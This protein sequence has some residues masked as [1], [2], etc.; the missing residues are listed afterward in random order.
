MQEET[1]NIIKDKEL[2]ESMDYQQLRKEAVAITQNISGSIWTD[3]NIHD[4]GVTILEQFCYAL[5]DI[6]Y[7]TN[8]SIETLLFHA[9]DTKGIAESNALF[10][11]E[12]I[13]PTG[14]ITVEDYTIL[15]LDELPNKISNCWVE[16]IMDHHE[17]IHGL[18]QI[19]LILKND[20]AASEH[21]NIK[22]EV[23]KI[24]V[25][26]RNLCEDIETIEIIKPEKIGISADI[27][28]F[29]DEV[30]DE[31]LAEILFQLEHYF[32]PIIQFS[33]LE[34]L[35]EKG[36]DLDEIFNAPSHKH[37]FIRKEQLQP[38]QEE[39][40]VSKIADHI[41]N[42][43]GV[44]NLRNL[45]VTQGQIPVHGDIIKVPSDKYLTLGL[46]G[47]DEVSSNFEGFNI[48]L[49]KGGI[50]NNYMEE[51]VAYALDIK[52]AKTHRNYEISTKPKKIETEKLRIGNLTNYE[53]IQKSFPRIYG[54]GHYF[55]ANEEGKLR[56]AQSS[57]LQAYLMF[58][59]QIMANHLAHLSKIS[60]LL[61]IEYAEK[62]RQ[63][64]YFSQLLS[65]D[66]PGADDLI[67]RK[68]L[69]KSVI[70]KRLLELKNSSSALSEGEEDEK[71]NLNLDLSE[72]ERL[73]KQLSSKKL[74]ELLKMPKS[75][76]KKYGFFENK[77]IV[78]LA[79]GFKED[80][81]AEEEN[82]K[83]KGAIEK[84]VSAK[85]NK[86]QEKKRK[87]IEILIEQELMEKEQF[88]PLEKRHLSSLNRQ[89]DP[90]S[91]RKNRLLTHMLARFGERFTT[92][93][94]I[95]FNSL[96]EGETQE[97]VNNKLTSLKSAF[98]KEIIS[99]SRFRSRGLNYLSKEKPLNTSIPLKRRICLLLNID[100]SSDQKLASARLNSK[101]K[102]EK[103]TGQDIVR[104]K[105][106]DK[107]ISFIRPIQSKK[108]ITFLV[109]SSSYLTY[110]F[111]FGL[112]ISNYK[113]TE[114]DG[115]FVT[116]FSPPTGEDATWIFETGSK[117]EGRQKIEKLI[118]FLRKLNSQSEGFHIVEHILL[119]T[120]ERHECLFHILGVDGL[121]AFTSLQYLPTDE[122]RPKA[123]DALLLACYSNNY[124]IYETRN[125]EFGV[126]LRDAIGTDL[127]RS[128]ATFMTR[129]SAEGYIEESIAYFQTIKDSDSFDPYYELD[130]QK[131][132]YLDLLDEKGDVIFRSIQPYEIKEQEKTIS[133]LAFWGTKKHH[134]KLSD[135]NSKELPL[136]SIIDSDGLEIARS[137]VKFDSIE[138]EN[139]FVDKCISYFEALHETSSFE[140]K[141]QHRRV[142]GRNASEFNAQLSVV[143]PEW[144][145]RF[146]NQEFLQLF[147]QT[148]FNCAPAHL[149][150]N[151]V[152]LNHVEMK[153]FEKLYFKYITELA[154]DSNK[155]E[156]TLTKM[157]N[158]ILD[159]LNDKKLNQT[160]TNNP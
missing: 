131:K 94:H 77:R 121:T 129:I 67:Q 112:N 142:D 114:E 74:D 4:P 53:S 133:D 22:N 72:K 83:Q 27:D 78:M 111:K 92:D 3:Y 65:P 156:S 39:F 45:S 155:K 47:N 104:E 2:R 60:E 56:Q 136:V 157:S 122:Q 103:L 40:Y 101:L 51:A 132:Y 73:V 6:A 49:F 5:T 141:I 69:P 35:T 66:T 79:L 24:F 14:P 102:M 34:E 110:L 59:D 126:I 127:A 143:Y 7:R 108:K 106:T 16:S 75:K 135:P 10:S 12:E 57:Q 58:F 36:Y 15:I 13:F 97:K 61:S 48:R 21:K 76:L 64:T 37:G 52:E 139:A 146:H 85:T 150:V 55:P 32:N 33:T 26:N 151:L 86:G 134:Y 54:I 44:R 71:D 80:T 144:T 89:F 70:Q 116:Y 8:L 153:D 115:N 119:R 148:V 81:K 31:V 125:N 82:R 90:T 38:K 123:K 84:G 18:Y 1:A 29:Q 20:V 124:Y 140:S 93:F 159:I 98:L 19:T 87:D 17:G 137:V 149:V 63:S 145:S 105:G 120:K 95:K 68:L 118:Q 128:N 28:I 160:G 23:K 154:K 96:L 11:A 107:K 138:K 9:G 130:N 109:N 42:V 30:A 91:N 152:G 113:I 88:V 100:H 99:L 25:A 158:E 41:L 147:K 50:V 43:K 62:N 117:E 46:S